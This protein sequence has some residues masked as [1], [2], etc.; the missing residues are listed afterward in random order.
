M[1]TKYGEINGKKYSK[2][3]VKEALKEYID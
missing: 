2:S 1:K 3:T